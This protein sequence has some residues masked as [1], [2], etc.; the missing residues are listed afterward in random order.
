MKKLFKNIKNKLTILGGT[1][2]STLILA[3]S[4]VL[5]ASNT[6]S[7]DG[8][9]SFACDWLTKIG[10]VIGLVGGVMFALGWQREDAEGKSR[11]LMTLMA[12]F[13]LVAIAQSKNLFGL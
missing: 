1:I 8:F 13:M 11:G 12:G 4:R 5:A 2:A 9:I 7:I 3:E 10:G 6:D